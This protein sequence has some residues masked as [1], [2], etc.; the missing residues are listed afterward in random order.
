MIRHNAKNPEDPQPVFTCKTSKENLKGY[1]MH[2]YGPSAVVYSPDKP[3][4]CGAKVW[5]QTTSEVEIFEN[6]EDTM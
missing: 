5:I 4:A 2:I 1:S 6:V 3:M